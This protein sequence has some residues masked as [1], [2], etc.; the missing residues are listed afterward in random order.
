MLSTTVQAPAFVLARASSVT[1]ALPLAHVVE[2]MRPLDL[3]P[4]PEAPAF[5]S[6]LSIVRGAPVPVVDLAALVGR[7][8]PMPIARWIALRTGERKLV[9][10]V[11]AVLGLRSIPESAL[12]AL[13][14]LFRDANPDHVEAIGTL[15]AE[16]LM[17]LRASRIIPEDLWET[18]AREGGR[19]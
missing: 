6:G 5:I 2:T 13:P 12:Q 10:A 18:L 4:I 19:A 1:C 3:R 7:G 8:R 14:P 17:V 15:D 16:L 11:E 9:L